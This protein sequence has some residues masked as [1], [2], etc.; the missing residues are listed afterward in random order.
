MLAASDTD[1]SIFSSSIPK[2]FFSTK[3]T[4]AS[5]IPQ[6]VSDT[7]TDGIG[8]F[9]AG[10]GVSSKLAWSNVLLIWC[11]PPLHVSKLFLALC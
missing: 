3:Q 7:V 11:G 9:G 10:L 2:V 8:L 4:S 5:L 6:P 1:F